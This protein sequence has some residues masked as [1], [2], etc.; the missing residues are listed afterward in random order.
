MISPAGSTLLYK[1]FVQ[2]VLKEREHEID[3]LLEQ[4]KQKGYS[5]LL[6]LTNKGFRYASNIFLN[7]AVLG[8]AYLGEH[9]KRS[10]STSDI[11]TGPAKSFSKVPDTLYEEEEEADPEFSKR[12]KE[13]RKYLSKG[14]IGPNRRTRSQQ[15]DKLHDTADD[16]LGE[17]EMANVMARKQQRTGIKISTTAEST[18]LGTISKRQMMKTKTISAEKSLIKSTAPI[19]NEAISSNET[20]DDDEKVDKN[21]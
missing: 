3:E 9:L 20:D 12:L 11:N 1:R 7:T 10:L 15:R 8:Q 4:T 18:H 2:P 13:D 6:D 14:S 19:E 17:M 21:T 5:A 16:P